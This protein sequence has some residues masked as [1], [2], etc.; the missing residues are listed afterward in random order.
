MHGDFSIIGKSIVVHEGVDDLG[1][2]CT[3]ESRK[4]GSAGPRVACCNIIQIDFEEFV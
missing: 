1:R 4:T 2:G 3:E